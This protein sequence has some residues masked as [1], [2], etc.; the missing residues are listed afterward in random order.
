MIKTGYQRNIPFSSRYL[1]EDINSNGDFLE[2]TIRF[3]I[4]VES[5]NSHVLLI[6]RDLENSFLHLKFSRGDLKWPLLAVQ[7]WW[8]SNL[9]TQRSS[10]GSSGSRS[11][12]HWS[13]QRTLRT[14]SESSISKSNV[15]IS[16]LDILKRGVFPRSFLTDKSTDIILITGSSAFE[17]R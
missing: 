15:D 13:F 9:M 10:K 8:R 3:F 2:F 4:T 12:V 1:P 7:Y 17:M 11:L 5:F 16:N 6:S 14:I